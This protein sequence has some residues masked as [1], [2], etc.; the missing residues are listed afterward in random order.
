MARCDSVC[1]RRGALVDRRLPMK[2]ILE[3]IIICIVGIFLSLCMVAVER[4]EGDLE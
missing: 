1:V 3:N 4:I 2:R